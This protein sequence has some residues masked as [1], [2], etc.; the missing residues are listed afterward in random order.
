M[1]LK[2]DKKSLLARLHKQ[3]PLIL[4]L[5]LA[6]GLTLALGNTYAWFT[7]S[8]T[9]R[10]LLE[11]PDLSFSFKVMEAFDSPDM[12]EPG[13]PITKEVNV[14]NAGTQTG[15]VRVLALPEIMTEDGRLLE[16]VPGITF[17]YGGLNVT[18]WSEGDEKLWAEGG[19]GYFYYLGTLEEGAVTL[20]PLFSS[21]TLAPNLPEEYK[22]ARMMVYIKV[23]AAET[24]KYRSSWWN[25]P[26]IDPLPEESQWFKIDASLQ[27]ALGN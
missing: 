4:L 19:D 20:E 22:N 12:F 18:D 5:A 1:N 6:I 14:T 3:R 23:E 10:N 13:V 11:T 25:Q 24:D 15:V 27:Q 21:V 2:I 8:D 17:T 9:V 7:S 16:A 26:D